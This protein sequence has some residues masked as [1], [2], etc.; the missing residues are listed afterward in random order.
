MLYEP[1]FRVCTTN[2]TLRQLHA[3]LLVLGYL[4][5]TP[6]PSSTP[7]FYRLSPDQLQTT[8]VLSESQVLANA[9]LYPRSSC[10]TG[11]VNKL[12]TKLIN[13][14]AK[15]GDIASAR[16]VF[17]TICRPDA[18]LNDVM[19]KG[20]VWNGCFEDAILLCDR[21]LVSQFE[22]GSFTFPSVL[23]A[24]GGLHDVDKGRK[25]HGRIIKGGFE[26]D[27]AIQTALIHMYSQCGFA[28]GAYQVFVR[29]FQRDAIS[30]GAM[31]LGYAHNGRYTE[32][33][34]VFVQ[35]NAAAV[36][37]DS[38]TMVGIAQACAGLGCLKQGRSVHGYIVRREI[39]ITGPLENS[40]LDMYGKCGDLYCACKLFN[41]MSK[42]DVYAWTMM[43]SY[44]NHCLCPRD[45]LELFVQM[46]QKLLP[47]PHSVTLVAVLQSCSQ[48]GSLREGKSVHGFITRKGLDF[49]ILCPGLIDMYV[50]CKR[51]SDCFKVVRCTQLKSV[52][53]CNSLI[54][55]YVRHGLPAEALALFYQMHRDNVSP[56][57][58]TL[59]SSLAACAD[60]S[61]Y[62]TGAL[63]HSHVIK[64]GFQS[65]EFIQ[66][67]I[68][69]MYC[70]SGF[71]DF[72]YTVFNGILEKSTI[73]WNTMIC[74]YAQ[75]GH[76][77]EAISL[78]DHMYLNSVALESVAFVSAVQ[79]C[80]LLGSLTKGKW[81]HHKLIVCG[82][83]ED[84]YCQT[85]V[86]DMYAKCGDILLARQVFNNIRE[87][88][89]VSWSAMISG[90]GMHGH[91][92]DATSLFN[93]M[94]DSGTKPN[95]VTFISLLAAC[96]HTGR[97]E[98]GQH[99]FDKMTKEFRLV[100]SSDHYACM[101]DL[102]SR[103]GHLDRA[104]AFI[105]KMPMEPTASTW[106]ALLT[107]CHIHGR[108]DLVDICRENILNL[109][110][111]NSGYYVQL[112]NL[113][114]NEREWDQFGKIRSTMKSA[115]LRKAPGFSVVELNSGIH[116]FNAGDTSHSQSKEI[117]SFLKVLENLVH[118][119]GK[120]RNMGTL[121]Q[122]IEHY[123]DTRTHSERLAIAFGIIN[124]KPGT[125]IR[126]IKNLRVC[127]ECHDFTKLVTK[128][129][130]RNIIMKDLNRFHHFSNGNCS[131]GDYW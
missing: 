46:Q 9:S 5:G 96:S 71:V 70:K 7:E 28:D 29:M 44:Y 116:K 52:E 90:Y 120:M 61:S 26:A 117:L 85:A 114:A 41:K 21:M 112:A 39:V 51:L 103:A 105:R 88:S 130:T 64:T 33:L 35:M 42:K 15:T 48:V 3:H 125:T 38:V 14:Y 129:T 49:E 16:L 113:Y 84:K 58:F 43:I 12:A 75:N 30:W 18:F 108:I 4:R 53:L 76:G 67:S 126:V 121:I 2:R 55:V 118:E 106:G 102:L 78:F 25:V 82:L 13:S 127:N 107:G 34:E 60:S 77:I 97:V 94:M 109:E 111:W 115:G 104:Y 22:H 17:D 101:I 98:Q 62:I 40:L 47:S 19:M 79:A 91:V 45:A 54:T 63:I 24:C 31:L 57:S 8:S 100:P 128:I 56:D 68:I 131:C 32:C 20:F 65:N 73:T 1:L 93:E 50:C 23:K 119:E 6:F 74:G 80:S 36:E 72:A 37:V 110:P 69:D 86:L 87:R 122:E 99:Y 10:R 59:A 92:D 83:H 124:T 27:C 123:R 95:G 66:N 89:V 11:Q 81:I